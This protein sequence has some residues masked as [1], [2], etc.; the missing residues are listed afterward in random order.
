MK[1]SW[2]Y[3]ALDGIR[4]LGIGVGYIL[5]LR[6]R[7]IDVLGLS[8]E[9]HR[10]GKQ[11][12]LHGVDQLV[13]VRGDLFDHT[14]DAFAAGLEDQLVLGVESSRVHSR[15]HEVPA[16]DLPVVIGQILDTPGVHGAAIVYDPFTKRAGEVDLGGSP[17]A[18]LSDGK[19]SVYVNLADKSAVAVVDPSTLTVTKT[20]QIDHCTSP[21]SLSFDSDNQ[22]LFVGC[23]DGLAVLDDSR[24]RDVVEKAAPL[25]ESNDQH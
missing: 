16:N 2:L 22:R 13:V 14:D 1:A 19:G 7:K 6:G 18:G 12:G 20:Y 4:K 24:R 25:I 17:E 9:G 10:L 8:V 15:A 21:H 23:R 3:L 5:K 11:L